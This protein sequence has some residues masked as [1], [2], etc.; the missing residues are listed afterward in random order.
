VL[1]IVLS[2]STVPVG[3]ASQRI[4]LWIE[5]GKLTG[6]SITTTDAKGNSKWEQRKGPTGTMPG[7]TQKRSP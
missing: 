7:V 5:D 6:A 4:H 3:Q 2:A 1:Y